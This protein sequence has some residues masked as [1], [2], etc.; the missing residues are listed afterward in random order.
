MKQYWKL[1]WLLVLL[2]P[3]GAVL[4]LLPEKTFRFQH[5]EYLW[6]LAATGVAAL[7]FVLYLVLR[8]R[9]LNAFAKSHLLNSLVPDVS[10]GKLITKFILLALAYQFTVIGFANPQ[11][12]TRQEKVT[13]KGIDVM[14]ALDVSNSMLSEDIK[15]NRLMRAKNFINNFLDELKNDR[16]GIIA[17][18]GKAELEMP[19]TS[20][21]SAGRM[22]LKSI[23][24]DIISYQGT[25]IAAAVNIAQESFPKDDL[26][27]N[28]ALIIITDG[29]DNEGGVEEALEKITADGVR[30]FT[31]GVGTQEGGPIP[32]GSNFKRDSKGNIVLSKINQSMLREI[33]GKGNGKYF[34]LGSGKDEVEAILNELGGIK[35]SDMGQMVFTDFDDKFQYCLALAALLLFID[36]WITE[37]KLRFNLGL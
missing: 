27:K 8:Q 3:V 19:I 28:R 15:P 2:L 32:D 14:I 5:P 25:D 34:Q 17:F 9:N 22:Y 31:L 37:R 21:Y 24:T 13:R 33:A 35:K 29:E 6:G 26:S 23:S 1:L 18:A 36:W 10:V 4:L 12:G 20:D 11:L 30:V 16:I 7:L